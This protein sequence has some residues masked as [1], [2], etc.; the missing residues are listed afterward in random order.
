MAEADQ[1]ASAFV[2]ADASPSSSPEV[3]RANIDDEDD[4][5]T[6]LFLPHSL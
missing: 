6:P 4:E 5:V 1:G 2:E 3:T